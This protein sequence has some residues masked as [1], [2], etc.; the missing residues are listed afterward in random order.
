MLQLCLLLFFLKAFRAHHI[1]QKPWYALHPALFAL[2][3]HTAV[4]LTV[5]SREPV[6]LRTRM[7]QHVDIY[8]YSQSNYSTNVVKTTVSLFLSAINRL[9]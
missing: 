5:V 3:C 6:S 4:K 2:Y 8:S 9:S 1:R 7:L